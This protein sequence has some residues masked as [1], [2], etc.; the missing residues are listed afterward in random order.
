[1]SAVNFVKELRHNWKTIGAVAP[2]STALA[3]RMMESAGVWK[4]KRILELGPGTGAFTGAIR[5]GEHPQSGN[6]VVH[7][8][9]MRVPTGTL[10]GFSVVLMSFFV[11]SAKAW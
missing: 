1:M 6:G 8:M 4:S 10:S 5:P 7:G 2:S 9:R 3:E 11:P